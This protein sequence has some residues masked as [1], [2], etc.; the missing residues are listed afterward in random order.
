MKDDLLRKFIKEEIGRNLHTQNTDPYTFKDMGDYDIE[1]VPHREGKF[2]LTI[3]LNGEKIMPVSVY[4]S[5]DD[6][7][8]ASRMVIDKDR[9]AR[10]KN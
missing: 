1:I 4:G 5:H 10:M 3:R 2:Y 6:A 8:H 9:V 7:V